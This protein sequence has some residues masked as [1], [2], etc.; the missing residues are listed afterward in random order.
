MYKFG[1]KTNYVEE[2]A[3]MLAVVMQWTGTKKNKQNNY[4]IMTVHKLI[5]KWHK[6]IKNEVDNNY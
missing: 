5:F 3:T 6:K 2:W 4:I 1:D